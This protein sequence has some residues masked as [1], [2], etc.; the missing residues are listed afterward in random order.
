VTLRVALYFQFY[1][2]ILRTRYQVLGLPLPNGT[3]ST[4]PTTRVPKANW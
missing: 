4:W 2:M 3:I 1:K